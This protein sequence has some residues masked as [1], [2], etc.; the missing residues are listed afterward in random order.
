MAFTPSKHRP[1][2]K[3]AAKMDPAFFRWDT[4]KRMNAAVEEVLAGQDVNLSAVARR[5]GVARPQLSKRVNE[6]RVKLKKQGKRAEVAR[7]ERSG[8]TVVPGPPEPTLQVDQPGVQVVE[9]KLF[10][11]AF[12]NEVIRVPPMR[13]FV[14]KY[15]MNKLICPDCGL[16][17]EIPQFHD[18]LMDT[19]TGPNKRIMVNV[20]AFHNKSTICTVW[21]TIYE[22]VRDPNCIQ[23][24]VSKTS[25]LSKRFLFSIQKYL[26]DDFLYEGGPSLIEDYGPFKLPGSTWNKDHFYIAGRESAEKDPTVQAIGVGGQVLGSRATRVVMDDVADLRNQ[27]NPEVVSDMVQWYMNEVQNRGPNGRIIFVGTRVA[28]NDIYSTIET[29]PSFD[30]IRYPCI[31]DE[32]EKKTLWPEHFSY[33]RAVEMRNSMTPEA[34]QLLYQNVITPGAGSSFPLEIVEQALDND[35]ILGQY[36][37]SWSLVIGL[38][39]AGAG[40]NSGFTALVLLGVERSSGKYHLI[41]MV[42]QRALKAHQMKDQILDWA[43]NYPIAELRVEANGIQSQL[44]QYD[45]ELMKVLTNRGIRVVPHYTNSNKWDPQFGVE[46]MAPL[47]YNHMISLPY[48]STETRHKVRALVDQLVAFPMHGGATDLVMATWFAYLG[49][50]DMMR[51]QP[52]PMFSPTQHQPHWKRKSRRVLDPGTGQFWSP[53]DPNLPDFGRQDQSRPRQQVNLVNVG[54]QVAVY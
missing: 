36:D 28:T 31:L 40:K 3:A 45:Q 37:P 32:V 33:D 50:K 53:D 48:G 8:L 15:F 12:T 18:D 26:S 20:A 46:S 25:S 43:A 24:L 34:W 30:V 22:M 16:K 4:S 39:P 42:N 54:R 44:V 10:V 52:A 47:F 6:L 38:D 41:D 9:R 29:L 7:V 14:R 35:R 51:Y 11:P 13:D 27:K 21:G 17:H 1:K 2:T 23:I 49:C 19:I 5:Y